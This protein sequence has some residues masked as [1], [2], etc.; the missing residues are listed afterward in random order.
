M[1]SL[2]HVSG[3]PTGGKNLIIVAAVDNVLHFRIFDANGKVIVDTD[4]KRLTERARQIEAL[5][6]QLESLWPP[7]EL[8]RGDKDRIITAVRSVVGHTRGY[9]N[10]ID[11]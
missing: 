3:V 7:H 2:N 8:W 10:D 5:R 1:S 6:K 9:S 11:R 4:E